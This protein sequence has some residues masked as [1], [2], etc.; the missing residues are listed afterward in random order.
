[1]YPK[2]EFTLDPPPMQIPPSSAL[3]AASV[4]DSEKQTIIKRTFIFLNFLKEF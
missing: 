2:L 4:T 1:M 3:T